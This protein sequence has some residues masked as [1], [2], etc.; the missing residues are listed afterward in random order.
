MCFKGASKRR[1]KGRF[2]GWLTKAG[3]RAPVTR[4]PRSR[5]LKNVQDQ[6]KTTRKHPKT[7]RNQYRNQSRKDHETRKPETRKPATT[8][9]EIRATRAKSIWYIYIYVYVYVYVYIYIYISRCL[10]EKTAPIRNRCCDHV[11]CWELGACLLPPTGTLLCPGTSVCGSMPNSWIL[12]LRQPPQGHLKLAQDL[13]SSSDSWY[14]I[15]I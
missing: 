4:I 1:K 10:R 8:K 6:P 11:P 7:D 5:A 2:R 15:Y 13:V 9:H 3:Q 14:Y 12:C